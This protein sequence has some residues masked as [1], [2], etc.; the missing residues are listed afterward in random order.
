MTTKAVST[1]GLKLQ[2]GDGA[3]SESFTTIA[4]LT[5]ISGPTETAGQIDATNFDS[6]AME[7]IAALPDNGEVT[8]EMNFIASDEQQQGLRA[9]LRAG[10]LRNFKIVLPDHATSP[11]TVAFSAIVTK[12]PEIAGSVNAVLRG[13]MTLKVSGRATWTYAPSI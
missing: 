6:E 8:A 5:N 11:T 12:A 3:A 7:Y 2:R 1:K 9:D 4:E 13:S 10:T